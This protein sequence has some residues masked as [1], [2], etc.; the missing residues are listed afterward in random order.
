MTYSSIAN[1]FTMAKAMYLDAAVLGATG[2]L[3]GSGPSPDVIPN[4]NPTPISVETTLAQVY[5]A[6]AVSVL[7]S[8]P[9]FPFSTLTGGHII[10]AAVASSSN[11]S[12][13]TTPAVSGIASS[14]SLTFAKIT[15]I[16]H[17]SGTNNQTLELWWAYSAVQLT[18]ETFTITNTNT[19][20][21]QAVSV[22]GFTGINSTVPVDVNGSAVQT[23]GSGS[24]TV[25]ISSTNAKSVALFAGIGS[26]LYGNA[27]A[28][29]GFTGLFGATGF[30][31]AVP[32]GGTVAMLGLSYQIETAALSAKVLVP[33]TSSPPGPV[34]FIE[35]GSVI[36][37]V[38]QGN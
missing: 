24:P 16:N 11:T 12:F 14:S 7:H 1:V 38:L 29:T 6:R 27:G 35:N 4:P 18:S 2:A 8:D 22:V 19:V 5:R 25:T 21:A 31:S 33:S 23:N 28:P 9:A 3:V 36:G 20:G 17:T 26:H 10:I 34:Y 13:G 37:A 15:S 32:G 30:I